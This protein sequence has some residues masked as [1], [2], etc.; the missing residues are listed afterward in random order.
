M[1]TLGLDLGA[2]AS[3]AATE[4]YGDWY[5]D[6]WAWP[7]LSHDFVAS[8]DAEVDLGLAVT[9]GGEYHLTKQPFFHLIDVPKSRLGVRPAVVQDPLSR[10]AYLSGANAGL[11]KLHASLP[12]WVYGWRKRNGDAIASGGPEWAAYVDSLP[13]RDADGYGLL[14]DITSFFASI[15][16]DRLQ[17]LVY[18]RLGK[19]TAAHVIMD[20]VRAHDSLSTR[21]GLPQRSFAS[22]VLAHAVLQPNDDALEAGV[23]G[24]GVT[25]VRRWMDDISAEGDEPAL[26]ALLMDLQ[27]RARQVGLELNSSKTHLSPV[28]ET[29]QTLRLEDLKEIRVPLTAVAAEDYSDEVRFEPDLEVLHKLEAAVLSK[30]GQ[31][32]ESRSAAPRR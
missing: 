12:D 6:P 25:S 28:S 16:P 24:P 30:T 2:G 19:V 1:Y 9:V 20:V 29:A 13:D 31:S 23:A 15:R 26:F 14:S 3:L 8:L 27:E 7:E 21:S 22:A 11:S 4:M 10:L 18:G 5:R 17:Q 32:A